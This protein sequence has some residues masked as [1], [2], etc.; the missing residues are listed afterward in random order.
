MLVKVLKIFEL[1][2]Y[3][4]TSSLASEQPLLLC[5][6]AYSDIFDAQGFELWVQRYIEHCLVLQHPIIIPILVIIA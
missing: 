3:N 1:K 2:H 5:Y 4:E 6:M